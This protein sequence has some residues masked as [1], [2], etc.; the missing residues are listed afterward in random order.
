MK[1]TTIPFR[2]DTVDALRGFAILAILLL[3]NIEHFD[4]WYFPDQLPEW[5]KSIDKAIWGTLFF[6][7]SGKAYSIF[8]I[9]FGVTFFIQNKRQQDKD[10]SFTGRFIWRMVLLMG[11][12]W[13]NT[14]FYLGDILV[15]YALLGVTLLPIRSLSNK[16]IVLLAAFL[17]LQPLEWT[18]WAQAFMSHATALPEPKFMAY[19]HIIPQYLA[20]GNLWE[21]M[22]GNVMVGRWG[23]LVWSWE[24]GRFFQTVA[25]FFTGFVLA[26]RNQFELNDTNRI[27]WKKTVLAAS[28]AWG[29]LWLLIY[30]M[31]LM[32]NVPAAPQIAKSILQGWANV[33]M[34][35]V[36]ISALSLSFYLKT[37]RK[38]LSYLI[39]AGRMSLSNYVGQS[40]AGAAIYYGFGLGLYACTGASYSLL[41]GIALFA[42]QLTLNKLWL[43]HHTQGPLEMIWHRLTW[44]NKPS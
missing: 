15:L 20:E 41:I 13:F 4:F 39:P 32:H 22:K 14:L 19:Y 24:A 33:A 7:F 8:A 35:L 12:G 10:N 29:L 3:H 18:R 26:R 40:V 44:L 34:T 9:L 1:H 23:S 43:T 30:L 37:P 38:I 6:L 2:L 31:S 21:V 25:L 16:T 27:F 17:F 11:F 5:M 42:V 28:I 36:W